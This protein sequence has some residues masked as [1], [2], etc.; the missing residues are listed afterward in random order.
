[1]MLSALRLEIGPLARLAWPMVLAELGW[2]TMGIVDTIFVGRLSTAALAGVS[3]GSVLF[4]SISLF[5]LGLLLGLDTLVSQAFGA[6]DEDECRAWAVNGLWLAVIVSPVLMLV[7]A[8]IGP[9]LPL[10][11]VQADAVAQAQ[12]YM[13][14]LNWS[15]PT[16]LLFA[17][18]R[19]YLQSM[20]IV[21]PVMIL[22]LSAN[23]INAAANYA[24]VFGHFGFPALGAAGAGWATTISRLYMLAGL[25]GYVWLRGLWPK[26]PFDGTRLRKLIQLGL[27]AAGQ[28]VL[29]VSLFA[30]AATLIGRLPTLQLAAH[31]IAINVVSY[32]FMVPLGLGSAA[33]VRVGQAVGRG[34]AQAA[35]HAGWSAIVL[36]AAFMTIAGIVFLANRHAVG[37]IFSSDPAVITQAAVLLVAGAAFQLFDGVQ[38]V[39]TGALRG[40]GDTTTPMLTHLVGYWLLGLPV[41]YWLCFH[42]GWGALGLWIGFCVA[43]MVIGITMAIMWRR[44]SAR[45]VFIAPQQATQPQP[46]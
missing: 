7:V 39:A 3:L 1:M 40:L 10:M 5:G 27:P 12:P 33:A 14:A 38:A 44:R 9:L 8:A 28:I 31:Q 43:L 35:R 6:G 19:R 23:L 36:G 17:A 25:A 46:V 24:L 13:S 41:G 26:G 11:G 45:I 2:M 20:N 16:L 30:V 42:R 29:E 4:Y 32:T 21:R 18:L 37:S 15:L 22:L 34:D